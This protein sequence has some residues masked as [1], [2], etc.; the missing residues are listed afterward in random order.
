[1]LDEAVIARHQ[2]L[3]A[4]GRSEQ[5]ARRGLRQQLHRD[6]QAPHQA[7]VADRRRAELLPGPGVAGQALPRLQR[8][9]PHSQLSLPV[10]VQRPHP[11]RLGRH[12][13]AV[14]GAA[15]G[16]SDP[17]PAAGAVAGAVV[18]GADIALGQDG[19]EAVG[20]LEVGGE[21]AQAEADGLGGE[22]AAAQ[23]RPDQEAGHADDQVAGV[24]ALLRRPADPLV[25]SALAAGGGGEQEAAEEAGPGGD[26]VAD[27]AAGGADRAERVLLCH[28]GLE[29][30]PRAGGAGRGD[31]QIGEAVDAVGQ[32]GRGRQGG[33]GLGRGRIGAART[34]R[35]QGDEAGLVEG[36][37]GGQAAA[38]AGLVASV[39]EAEGLADGEGGGP[40]AGGGIGAEQAAQAVEVALLQQR[41]TNRCR[42]VHDGQ[43]AGF[44]AIC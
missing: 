9:H 12:R 19:A 6:H 29:Q 40:A 27:L 28:Q 20:L 38:A 41:G 30:A 7:G 35:G 42:C 43:H 4:P 34:G 8:G 18:A 5:R 31:G 36:G 1:M 14:A 13:A 32:G 37:E 15:G 39:E 25:A 10:R 11:D 44:G 23:L 22:V 17:H 21:A 33:R 24:V 16:A 2:R 3:P 26:E